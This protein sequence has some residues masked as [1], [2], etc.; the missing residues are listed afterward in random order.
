MSIT[1]NGVE[2]T[3]EELNRMFPDPNHETV[4]IHGIRIDVMLA[5]LMKL[6]WS[7]NIATAFSC[8]GD[9]GK[10][11]SGYISFPTKKYFSRY[12]SMIDNLDKFN[13]D[14]IR[15]DEVMMD[16][17]PHDLTNYPEEGLYSIRFQQEDIKYLYPRGG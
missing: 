3:M 8:Q 2:Y 5:D 12:I 6:L 10:L 13:F 1:I 14:F 15:D 16:L 7:M 9:V 11:L 17:K 4:L